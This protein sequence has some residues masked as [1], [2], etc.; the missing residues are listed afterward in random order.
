VSVWKRFV[1]DR[2][3]DLARVAS[4]LLPDRVPVTFVGAEATGELCEAIARTRSGRLG[5]V[6][7]EGLV[8][9]GIVERVTAALDAASQPWETFAEVLPDPT[10]G[11]VEAGR[12]KLGAAGC[13]AILA[14]GGGSVMDA[15]KMIA[16][17]ATNPGPV[18]KLEGQLK[19]RKP[20]L[21]LYAIPTTAG[22]GS[23]VTLVAVLSD[24]DSHAK[25]F[26]IDP[27]LLPVMVALDPTLMTGL[28]P[29]ITAATG[30]DALTHAV[31]SVLARTAT[32]QTE[33]YARSALQRIFPDLPRAYAQ[34]DDLAARK[35]MALAS[36]YAG[37]AFTRTSVGYVHAIAHTFGAFYGTPHGLANALALP[38]VLEFSLETAG[39]RLA[40]MADWIGV[41]GE[42]ASNREKAEA[43]IAAVRELEERVQIPAA[44]E[45]LRAEDVP[46]IAQRAVKEAHMNYPVPRY[47]V[48]AECEGLLQRILP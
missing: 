35:S 12:A 27:K 47:M 16:A 19:V 22:T 33:A 17:G 9:A 26:F 45:A 39:P 41:A 3:I 23:E 24:P 29:H 36:Y 1:H 43:F 44:L 28:P 5:I 48:Q 2:T 31:E 37:L 25:K 13:D 46:A 21:P 14:V 18:Q 42:G 7:D 30:L 20:P 38:H 4:K 32:P 40:L 34:G 15:A 11:Q 10:F 6:T 8:A